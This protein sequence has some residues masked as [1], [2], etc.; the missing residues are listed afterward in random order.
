M[1]Y[2]VTGGTGQIGRF[3]IPRLLER[4]GTVYLLVSATALGEFAR[5]RIAWG[6][7]DAQLVPVVG[8]LTRMRLGVSQQMQGKLKHKLDHFF[9]LATRFDIG[10]DGEAQAKSN[11]DVVRRALG[12][13]ESLHAGCFHLLSSTAAAGRYSGTFS[14]QMFGEAQKLENPYYANYHYAERLV[15]NVTRIPWRIYRPGIIVG[16]SDDGR[17]TEA[18]GL[19]YFFE[20]LRSLG[21]ALPPWERGVIA[22]GGHLNLVPADYVGE[23]LDHLAHLKKRNGECFML[24][25]PLGTS[26]GQVMQL[27]V[28]LA[29]GPGLAVVPQRLPYWLVA[30][31]PGAPGYGLIERFLAPFSVPVEA[32]ALVTSPTRFDGST[33]QV[34][35]EQGDIHCPDFEDYAEELWRYWQDKVSDPA[36]RGALLARVVDGVRGRRNPTA[37]SRA[38]KGRIVVVAGATGKLGRECALQLGEAGAVVIIVG[39]G[40]RRLQTLVER[41]VRIG[42]SPPPVYTGDVTDPVACASVVQRVLRDYGHVDVLLNCDKQAGSGTDRAR[43]SGTEGES[44]LAAS[45]LVSG[46]SPSMVARRQGHIVN[47]VAGGVLDSAALHDPSALLSLVSTAA[48]I[49]AKDVFSALLSAQLA[50]C[51]VRYSHVALPALRQPAD[52]SRRWVDDLL[53]ITPDAAAQ[54]VLKTL[55]DQPTGMFRALGL[56]GS[57]VQGLAPELSAYWLRQAPGGQTAAPLALEV[58]SSAG[59]EPSVGVDADVTPEAVPLHEIADTPADQRVSA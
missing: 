42:V 18:N 10:A 38:V 14:E 49:A 5:L 6:A 17:V 28:R 41:F 48:S 39:S 58:P 2:F 1:I 55:A 34:L 51:G 44:Q 20:A 27:L 31:R 3:L 54:R 46:F 21:E 23:A 7:S 37:L 52:S 47:V 26:A 11:V 45:H 43:A 35:L 56:T 30:L 15:R 19:Y 50:S 36:K 13:A 16:N 40:K 8:D 22:D 24:T 9:H 25:H 12:L 57:V 29:G 53:S 59:G 32:L 33:T 4:G